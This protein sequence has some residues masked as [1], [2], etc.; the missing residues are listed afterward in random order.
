MRMKIAELSALRLLFPACVNVASRA[1]PA[2]KAVTRATKSP[3]KSAWIWAPPPNA[4]VAPKRS[5]MGLLVVLVKLFVQRSRSPGAKLPVHKLPSFGRAKGAGRQLLTTQLIP[6]VAV[7]GERFVGQ[8]DSP[9][10]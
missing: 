10:T 5:A 4:P 9:P 7:P 2:S 8:V 3:L 1:R 6:P